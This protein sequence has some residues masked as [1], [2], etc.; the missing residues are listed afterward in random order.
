VSGLRRGT[1]MMLFGIPQP[2]FAYAQ[3]KL[4][5][6]EDDAGQQGSVPRAKPPQ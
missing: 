3:R 2:D 5:S 6:G 4:G 1:L